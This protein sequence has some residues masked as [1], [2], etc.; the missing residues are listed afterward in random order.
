MQAFQVIGWDPE[1]AAMNHPDVDPYLAV[2]I[3]VEDAQ[4][5][6]ALETLPN[7]AHQVLLYRFGLGPW[8]LSRFEVSK[9]L[10]LPTEEVVG[11]E[12]SAVEWLRIY[13]G[14]ATAQEAA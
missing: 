9:N 8:S 1:S 6:L 12:R 3:D 10:N 14:E 4:V 5:Q 13:F 2:V 7:R 11:I